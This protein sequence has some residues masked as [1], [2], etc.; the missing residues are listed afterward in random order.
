MGGALGLMSSTRR[1][2]RCWRDPPEPGV[3]N[4]G[5]AGQPTDSGDPASAAMATR[6]GSASQ[7]DQVFDRIAQRAAEDA[8]A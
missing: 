1:R 6:R 5:D 3:A 2:L 7:P 4:A 8:G